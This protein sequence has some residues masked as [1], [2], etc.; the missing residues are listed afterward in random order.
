MNSARSPVTWPPDIL[1]GKAKPESMPIRFQKD[2]KTLFNETSVKN[3]DLKIPAD[4]SHEI[5]K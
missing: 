3:L 4:I 1:E 2:F 5:V